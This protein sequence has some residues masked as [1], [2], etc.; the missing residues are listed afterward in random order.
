MSEAESIWRIWW[1]VCMHVHERDLLLAQALDIFGPYVSA[2]LFLFLKIWSLAAHGWVNVL[3][4]S[5][6]LGVFKSHSC[7]SVVAIFM[8]CHQQPVDMCMCEEFI[9]ALITSVSLKGAFCIWL[10]FPQTNNFLSEEQEFILCLL[11]D[12]ISDMLV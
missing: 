9:D 1:L 8:P 7:V 5:L 4:L 11:L 2:V 6:A 12:N 3:Y 10:I